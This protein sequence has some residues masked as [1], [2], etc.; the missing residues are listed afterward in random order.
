MN[1]N[2]KIIKKI[3]KEAKPLSM[4]VRTSHNYI[5]DPQRLVFSLVDINLLQRCLRVLPMFSRL[6]LGMDLKVQL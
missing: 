4:G 6:E 3:L 2:K 5:E 1:I